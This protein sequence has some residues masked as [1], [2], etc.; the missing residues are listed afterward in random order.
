MSRWVHHEMQGCWIQEKGHECRVVAKVLKPEGGPCRWRVS[1]MCRSKAQGEDQP[2]ELEVCKLWDRA[3]QLKDQQE[4]CAI[5]CWKA[6]DSDDWNES[7]SR[8][9]KKV[10]EL[11]CYCSWWWYLAIM[12]AMSRRLPAKALALCQNDGWEKATPTL[13]MPSKQM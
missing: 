10:Y 11:H 6:T 13:M 7:K 12:N 2:D 9:A 1:P 5:A 3:I 4:M 8:E